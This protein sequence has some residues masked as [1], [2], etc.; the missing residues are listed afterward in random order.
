MLG[1]SAHDPAAGAAAAATAA[2]LLLRPGRAWQQDRRRLHVPP[3]QPRDFEVDEMGGAG[4][5]QRA[6]CRVC[7]RGSP[8]CLSMAGEGQC[9]MLKRFPTRLG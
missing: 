3:W 2:H 5:G 1:N 6:G 4:P 8:A 7:Y 9:E